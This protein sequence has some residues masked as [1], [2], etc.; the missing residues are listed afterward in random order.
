[1][2]SRATKVKTTVKVHV[3]KTMDAAIPTKAADVVMLVAVT[4]CLAGNQPHESRRNGADR[5]SQTIQH[6]SYVHAPAEEFTDYVKMKFC[7][8]HLFSELHLLKHV[9][10]LFDISCKCS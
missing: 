7:C 1:M 10:G 4:L 2:S 5:S 8:D 3:P 6:L 9:Y